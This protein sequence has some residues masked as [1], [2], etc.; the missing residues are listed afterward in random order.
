[1]SKYENPTQAVP[2]KSSAKVVRT[3]LPGNGRP[4]RGKSK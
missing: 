2:T 3:T 1:M 4:A